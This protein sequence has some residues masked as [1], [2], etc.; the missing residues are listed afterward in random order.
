VNLAGALRA[1]ALVLAAGALCISAAA[2]Q[3]PVRPDSGARVD[4]LRLDSLRLQPAPPTDTTGRRAAPA[5]VAE[6]ADTTK[7]PRDTIKAPIARAELPPTIEIADQYRW[8]RD[9]L[10]STGALTLGDL[11]ERIPGVTR[12]R[13]GWLASPD[14][15][16]VIGDI[17]RLRVFYDGIE[18]SPIDQ[19][20]GGTLDLNEV[21]L[22]TLEEV[23]VE[24][25][26]DEVRVY[27]RSWRVE[28]TTPD[29]RTD[30]LTGDEDTNLYRGFF[31]KRFR[32]GE[33]LQLA[34]QQYGYD[35]RNAAFG[36]GDQLAVLGRIG[37][38]RR[39]W[40]VDAFALR[41]SR[42]RD[43]QTRFFDASVSIPPLKGT[44]TDAYVRA[45][46]GDPDTGP[47]LQLLAAHQRFDEQSPSE[48]N[49]DAADTT[50]SRAQYVATGGARVGPFRLSGGARLHVLRDETV[51][52]ITGRA[53]FET[54][55]LALSLRTEQRGGDTSSVEEATARL[56]PIPWLSLLGAV[57]RRHGGQ[58]DPPDVLSMRAEAG[59]RLRRLWATGGIMLKD[60]TTA[61]AAPVLFDPS[62]VAAADG[63]SPRGVFG[64]LRGKVWRDVYADVWAVRW[65]EPGWYRPQTQLRG[66]L[67]VN[68]NWLS[69]FP[70]GHFQFIAALALEYRGRTLF[71]TLDGGAEVATDA[72]QLR[73]MVEVRIL[74]GYIFWQQIYRMSPA[75][76]Q[77]VP[78]YVVQRQLSVFGARWQF[79]N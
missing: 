9:R 2:A 40:S 50:T 39:G 37:F 19:R 45:A 30:V 31:G 56:T 74:D 77:L 79:W 44:R 10:F 1:I 69:R 64:T 18:I 49:A 22:W 53:A 51:T 55:M 24:R 43:L 70:Q 68:T 75:Q 41:S 26:A 4:T 20:A 58:G 61:L 48:G 63:S 73:S 57:S 6:R 42:T 17:G 71:P 65:D 52:A 72:R 34:A 76:P 60:T 27:L 54:K 28:R 11:L 66:E 3:V 46:A 15:A 78:G 35:A 23:A 36:G 7:T 62:Y 21:Q 59:V 12:F 38:A 14:H 32:H 67:G 16:A 13:P 33:A 5:E 29:T 8:G 25:G 47:W